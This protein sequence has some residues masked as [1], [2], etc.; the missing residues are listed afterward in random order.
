MNRI[1]SKDIEN[2]VSISLLQFIQLLII[3]LA[4]NHVF[5]NFN[6][7]FLFMIKYANGITAHKN[8]AT[9]V[10]SAAHKIHILKTYIKREKRSEKKI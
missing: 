1:L 10:A 4:S 6:L 2:V 5:T 8:W 9:A 7:D 3:G